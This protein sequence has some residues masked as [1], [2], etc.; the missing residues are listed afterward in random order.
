MALQ[1]MIIMFVTS[2]FGWI[3]GFLS[4]LSRVLP[5][6]LNICLLATGFLVTLIHYARN[7]GTEH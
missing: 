2:P 1:H 5:F 3:G 7:P 6:V 4:E